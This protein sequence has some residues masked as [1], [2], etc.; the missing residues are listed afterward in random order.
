MQIK[1]GA[2]QYHLS[3]STIHVPS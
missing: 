2:L 1:I 3:S